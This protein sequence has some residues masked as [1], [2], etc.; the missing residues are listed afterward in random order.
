MGGRGRN[1]GG[2]GGR[3]KEGLGEKTGGWMGKDVPRGHRHQDVYSSF[4]LYCRAPTERRISVPN[5]ERM[6]ERT[7]E[8]V[9]TANRHRQFP[10][11]RVCADNI[12]KPLTN[13]TDELR[14]LHP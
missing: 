11:S 7:H 12:R 1:E 9:I 13:V 3:R 14:I 8:T 4:P 2:E 6:K 10:P 5:G